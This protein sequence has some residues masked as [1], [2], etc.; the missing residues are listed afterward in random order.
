VVPFVVKENTLAAFSQAVL[1]P[2]ILLHQQGHGSS[3]ISLLKRGSRNSSCW[4]L[5]HHTDRTI[6]VFLCWLTPIESLSVE[7]NITK[8]L[9]LDILS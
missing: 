2:Y 5:L 3:L 4:P 7:K 6:L 8:I 1:P 9:K